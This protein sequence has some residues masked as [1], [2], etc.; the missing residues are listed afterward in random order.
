[1]SGGVRGSSHRSSG[2]DRF[3]SFPVSVDTVACAQAAV[4]RHGTELGVLVEP[5]GRYRP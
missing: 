4:Q 2:P 1:M 3:I 5:S